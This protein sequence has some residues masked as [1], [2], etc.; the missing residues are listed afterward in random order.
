MNT[1]DVEAL[2]IMNGVFDRFDKITERLLEATH[3]ENEAQR[4]WILALVRAGSDAT[5]T[6]FV[7]QPAKKE[8]RANG[9]RASSSHI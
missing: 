4:A 3:K 1:K 7:E 6:G 9:V 2:A 8:D 5:R